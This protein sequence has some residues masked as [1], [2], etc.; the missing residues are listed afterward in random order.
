MSPRFRAWIPAATYVA[1]LILSAKLVALGID[2]FL[3]PAATIECK[4]PLSFPKYDYPFVRAFGLTTKQPE[5]RKRAAAPR[6]EATLKGYTLTMTAVGTP[7]MAIIVHNRKSKLLSVGE[8][9]D[10]FRLEEV[11]TDRVKLVKNGRDYW[12]SMKKSKS[13]IATIVSRKK[14]PKSGEL[15]EQIRQEGNTYYVPRELLTQMHDLKKIFQYIAISP[16]YRD[17]K[18][19]GF[20]VANVKKGS[21]FDK[22]GLRKR[23]IIEKVDGKPITDEGDAFKYFNNINALDSLSLTI[24]RGSER[25]ELHYEIY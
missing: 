9:I 15:I 13:G 23:D 22:M 6:P 7:S 1:V 24:K 17:N 11:Y 19:V 4:S 3:P 8:S 25:K 5:K 16:V 14:K 18:L 21:V 2:A 20:G 12:L 10:G